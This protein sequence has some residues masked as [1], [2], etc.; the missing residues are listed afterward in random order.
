MANVYYRSIHSEIDSTYA[1]ILRKFVFW[2]FHKKLKIFQVFMCAMEQNQIRSKFWKFMSFFKNAKI[3][4]FNSLCLNISSH[5]C[6]YSRIPCFM[7]QLIR[8]IPWIK[9]CLLHF[10]KIWNI[11]LKKKE[12]LGMNTCSKVSEELK[13]IL[14]SPKFKE[15]WNGYNDA[16]V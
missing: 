8:L 6:V 13:I 15:K 16:R 10:E 5:I 14:T 4:M 11:F 7:C 1:E 2:W 9:M 3:L 12:L